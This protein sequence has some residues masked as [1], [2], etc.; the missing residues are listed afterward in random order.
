MK[1]GF[2]KI[3]AKVLSF[4]I[5]ATAVAQLPIPLFAQNVLAGQDIGAIIN[6]DFETGDLSGWENTGNVAVNTA[7]KQDGTCSVKFSAAGSTLSQTLTGIPQGSYTLS[8][9]VKGST[10]GN[11]ATITATN[12]GAPD[13][14][15]FVDGF[16]SSTAWTHV[17]LRNV[18]VYNGQ[19]TITVSSGNGTNLLVDNIQLVLDSNDNNPITNWNLE[20]GLTGWDISGSVSETDT[21]QDTGAMAAVLSADSQISQTVA[22]KPDTSYI[23]TV[24]AKVD[25][26]DVWNKIQQTNAFGKTGELIKVASYGD[27]INLGVKGKNGTVLR[28]APAGLEGYS[29]LTIAFKTGPNDDQITI[30]ANTIKD[31]N[32]EKSVKAYGTGATQDQ[33]TGNGS[34][35]A[36]V[37]NFDLF[38]I[39]NSIIK[40]A[41]VSFLP[42]IEDK[43]GKYFANG[44][45]QDCLTIMSNHGV[46]AI[47]G[48]IFVDSGSPIYDQS[49]PKKQQFTSYIDADGNPIPYTMQEGYFGKEHWY[50]L[51]S[52][53]K[54]L[55]MGYEPSFHFSDGWMSAA[56]AFTPVDW[57]YK[58]ST[59]K[60]VDQSLDEMTTTVYN[61]VY[62]F[63][64]G[65]KDLGIEPSSAKLGNEQDGGIAWPNGKI[66]STTIDGFKSLFNAAYDATKAV[67]PNTSCSFHTN[68]GYNVD[69]SK[70]LFNRLITNGIKVDGE[71]HSL[72]SG[73]P[74]SDIL[75]MGSSNI[76]N[77]PALDYLNVETG[78]AVTRYNPD[79]VDESGSMGQAGYYQQNW[80]GQYNWLLDYMQAHRD[81]QNPFSRMR[82]FFYWAA[83]WIVVEGAG[84]STPDGNTVDRRTLFNNGDPAF[85]E[86]GST[87][88]GKMGDMTDG[89]YAYLWRGCIKD[90]PTSMQTP[91]KGFGDYSI[92]AEAPTS[93]ALVNPSSVSQPQ[94]T[95]ELTEGQTKRLLSKIE[96]ADGALDW[97]VVW[98]SSDPSV[99]AVDKHGFVTALAPGQADITVTTVEGSLSASCTV[100]VTAAATVGD[101]NLSITVNG[102]AM[103]A[104]MNAMV[105]DKIKLKASVPSTATNKVVKFVSSN[106]EVANF[107]GAPEEAEEA[108]VLFQQTDLT[109]GVQLD[110][111]QPG[112]TVVS[113]ISGDGTAS[114]QFTLD[115]AK[116]PVESITLNQNSIKMSNGRTY[117]LTAAVAPANAS[118][119]DVVWSSSDS[120]VAKVDSNGLIS[121]VGIGTAKITAASVDDPAKFA[122]CNIEV[123]PV[124]VEGL[125]LDKTKLNIMINTQKNIIPVITPVDAGNKTVT[126]SSDNESVATVDANGTVTGH[127]EGTATITASANDTSNGA[128][129]ASC[130]VNVQ[131]TPVN[132]AGV[133]LNKDTLNFK[134]DY[135]STA[136]KPA[137]APVEKLIA[138]V[139]PIDATNEDIIWTSDN[140]TVA[141][142]DAFGNVTALKSGNAVITATTADGNF[143]AACKVLVP[144]VSESFENRLAGDNWAVTMG[145]AAPNSAGVF[146]SE[147]TKEAAN[148][149]NNVLK[150]SAGG[151][152]I[153]AS[154]KVFANP[155][156]NGKI[157]FDFDWNVGAP[158]AS[159]GGQLSI[160]DAN[161]KRYLTLET[162]NNAEM[163]YST[164]GTAAN[165]SIAGTKVGTGFNVNNTTYN[166]KAT[167][168]FALK[169][170]DLTVTNKAN[171]AITSTINNIPFNA[172]T[173]YTNTI[174][175]IQFVATR[176]GSMSWTTWIDNFNVYA[177][178][179]V[180]ASVSMNKTYLHL[181]NIAG[182]RSNTAQLTAVVNP[183]VSGIAQDVVWGSSNTSVAT[184]SST[185]LVKAMPEQSGDV[186]ITA[187]SVA[188]PSLSAVCN[189]KVE[190][191]Y[192]METLSIYSTK[193]PAVGIEDSTV[194]MN[195]G[196]TLQLY[197]GTSNDC[198]IDTIEWVSSDANKVFVDENGM[199]HAMAPGQVQI[200]VTVDN[201]SANSQ[202]SGGVKLTK[203]VTINVSGEA[204]LNTYEL[205]TAI[206][207]ATAA[208]TKPDDYY[209]QDSLTA[210][211]AALNKAQNDLA[212]AI[213]DNW[214]ASHQSIIDQDVTE[215]NAAVQGLARSTNIAV[216]GIT[217]STPDLKVSLGAGKQL[218]A[219]TVPE[220]AT[221]KSITWT[222][223][224]PAVAA[225][226]PTGLVK[227]IAA[228]TAVITAQSTNPAVKAACSVTV[229][230]DISTDYLANGGSVSANKSRAQNL[231]QYAL[232]SDANTA[233]STGGASSGADWWLLDLGN[234][235][236]IDSLTMNFWMKAK[237]SVETSVDGQSWHRVVDESGAFAGD[238][239][240]FTLNMPENTYGRYIRV[241]FYAFQSGW[242][243]LVY[244]Q[245]KGEFKQ[246]APVMQ[247]IGNKSVKAGELLAFTIS[248]S[249]PLGK[250]ITY[251]A[252]GLPDGAAL[253]PL[254]GEFRWTP[255]TSGTHSVTLTASN[256]TESA[257][258][259]III[260]VGNN[261]NTAPVINSIGNKQVNIGE[262]LYFEVYA[263]DA[264]GDTL[265]LSVSGLPQ[266]AEFN[267]T[268][269][270]AFSW[271]PD[272]AGLYPVT[273]MVT[274]GK[275]GAA[276][277]TISITVID[278][279]TPN[280]PP[281]FTL[282][283]DQAAVAGQ[284]LVFDVEAVDLDADALI[285]GLTGEAHGA[286]IDPASGLFSWIPQTEGIYTF[287]FT[288]SDGKSQTSMEI[289]VTVNAPASN[290]MPVLDKI[291]D[292]QVNLGEKLEF[293]VTAADADGDTLL[294]NA[295][296][297]PEGAEF[298][299]TTPGAFSWTPGTAGLYTVTF[300]VSDG[301]GGSASET[302][303]IAV[304]D[305]QNLNNPPV[306]TQ[307]DDQVAVAGQ[308]LVM[309]VE[310]VDLD[311]DPMVYGLTGETHGAYIDAASGIFNWTPQAEGSYRF[312]FTVS[313]G[314]SITTKSIT[315]TVNSTSLN[316]APVLN[317]IGNKSITA[318]Y[319]LAFTVTAEDA[320][321]DP[322]TYSVAGLP[323]GAV[324]NSADGSFSWTP[325]SAGTYRITFT[326]QDGKG[327]MDSETVTITV[328]PLGNNASI[329][330]GSTGGSSGTGNPAVTDKVTIDK[331]NIT[332]ETLSQTSD[333]TSV[334]L[335]A[336][337]IT[338]AIEK[339]SDGSLKINVRP[340]ENTKDVKIE[341]PLRQIRSSEK[342]ISYVFVY[343]GLAELSFSTELLKSV[344]NA[345]KVLVEVIKADTESLPEEV[346]KVIGNNTVY[347]FKLSIDGKELNSFRNS[348]ELKVE[349]N[350]QLKSG[351]NPNNIVVYYINDNGE[352]EV[353]KNGI[354]NTSSGKVE[355]SPKHFSKYAAAYVEVKFTDTFRAAWAQ[356]SIEALAA[357]EVVT[358]TGNNLFNPT[359]HITRG[360]FIAMLMNAFELVDS[361]AISTFTD[362]KQGAWYYS[363]VASAEKLGITAGKANGTFGVNDRITRQDMAVLA[364]RVSQLVGIKLNSPSE[365]N[366]KDAGSIAGYAKEAITAMKSSGII[367]GVGDNLMAPEK[368]TTRAEAAV[369]IYNLFK[370]NK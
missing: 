126:W 160:E 105:W 303:T 272:A 333:K 351:Q 135:F 352:L 27:R 127:A 172:A 66:Y 5:L 305:P 17:A 296:C 6:S 189:V 337:D 115:T 59:G 104:S 321:N 203:S 359:G 231:P 13:T 156:V 315:I 304:N 258:E 178:A 190:G 180:P 153:R 9:W 344:E 158:S 177:A 259:T 194:N 167:L 149:D 163:T 327:G 102:A 270:G 46:N 94:T 47:T 42:I 302:I 353:V 279:Q 19:C 223:D 195:T 191:F 293:I 249:D 25:R 365:W 123:V 274:D 130:V 311:A 29:L 312:T 218:T 85:H 309:N 199:L 137:D 364:Y 170:I 175:K 83:E 273:F 297:L 354:F 299:T 314:R 282:L 278:S 202:I 98:Y 256:G 338:K 131:T 168:N 95:L 228:G 117:Q 239:V 240:N 356:E 181:L 24:R 313:D 215:L 90:K 35:K 260:E 360:E 261:A 65:L 2:K 81:L 251:S 334:A 39:D 294:L 182:T 148:I 92:S 332:I 264:D 87:A 241:N 300:N 101:G 355:F 53:A 328:N 119:G 222:S 339:A 48:M 173:T 225:V 192:P 112:T 206:N 362:V 60:L 243:G 109:A 21:K 310:A 51:A 67:F 176:S 71:A 290:N 136:N 335:K 285:Y 132:V 211:T 38:E 4:A 186:A 84:A 213:N 155:I 110:V 64:K 193:S 265:S 147:S 242:V 116:I 22:V 12:T 125:S 330:S 100:N 257:S 361:D 220:Y 214:D 280:N 45:Q 76:A 196:E 70:A 207:N 183:N 200:S 72:Y 40:G 165:S 141:R 103:P 295:V 56:K 50:G 263:T 28:Q 281:V 52:R 143:T 269:P 226:G 41:D 331:N 284:Q 36:Y 204:I 166:I 3:I 209:S 93:I 343:T 63:M 275:G 80:N 69:N 86:M 73:H 124:M 157:I 113:A 15:L 34:D 197:T 262:N 26:Q 369:I 345:E 221:D 122:E 133:T 99:A 336:D 236:K 322:I 139:T 82:G 75:F 271:T 244:F 341:I 245:A 128:Y 162:N 306:F 161:N 267:T 318:G 74:S 317:T 227:G 169:T 30:Y 210:Y 145:S 291:G 106:P 23:A 140:E 97:E 238:T 154:Q 108:G 348:D 68:N 212:A 276:S 88:D 346:K 349:I 114:V 138:Q 358:G 20:N 205:K 237:Y 144:V 208:K 188:D 79:F 77:F 340:A 292:K 1:T 287:T 219:T 18:L 171:P 159:Y 235:A 198:F 366:F 164:G 268:T 32:Y 37:D 14:K 184:V 224:N 187:T 350:Y 316:N 44:V 152:G 254:T 283:A 255:T 298:N 234:T 266:G 253:D 49:S 246:P 363:A 370:L 308:L 146:S 230:N 89:L 342:T 301:R 121:S 248:A 78:F 201:Y 111:K 232:D 288:V 61:Y 326:A 250:T 120:S 96:P 150:L 62:D 33:W 368:N 216:T 252:S 329:S 118:F 10:S 319:T 324:F 142:V 347:D 323:A 151:N 367:N 174:S 325:G 54:E 277:E 229:T 289:T 43:G 31:A 247:S 57:M 8:A 233:W 129:S 357:R 58:D 185:G 55:N 179:P 7:D 286:R 91:L 107:L 320:D 134:S 11:T 307:L 16:I 217:L